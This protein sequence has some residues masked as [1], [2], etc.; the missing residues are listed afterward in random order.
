MGVP[1]AG[2]VIS[3]GSKSIMDLG[4]IRMPGRGWFYQ[5]VK[6]WR[7]MERSPII[8]WPL[9]GELSSGKDRQL[10]KAIEVLLQD[11]NEQSK[12]VKVEMKPASKR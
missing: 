11:V 6:I 1:T 2:G 10:E 4:T 7:E 12:K 8:V 5:M 3:T 9:P